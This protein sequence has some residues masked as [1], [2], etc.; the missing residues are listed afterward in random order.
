MNISGL[1][2]GMGGMPNMSAMRDKMFQKAD[3]NGDS[4]ISLEEFQSAGKKMP[5]GHGG[6]SAKS[7]EAFGKIDKDGNGSLSKDE[8]SAFGDKMSSQMQ[9]MMLKMQEMMSGGGAG[10]MLGGGGPN[11]EALFGKADTDQNGG[12]SRSEFDAVG[13]NNPL[14]KLLGPEK[15]DDAFGK[16]DTDGDGNLSK[17]EFDAFA[18]ELKGKMQS[19]MGGE[20]GLAKQMEAMSA[21]GKG[22]TGNASTDM[23]SKLLDMLEGDSKEKDKERTDI[24]A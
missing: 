11:P 22:G 13:K 5:I 9:S 17:T 6:D 18:E 2:G 23:M 1:M 16:I 4:G 3:A 15:N 7:A 24:A 21:Y 19:L 10:G 14:A 20:G 12:I 8:M